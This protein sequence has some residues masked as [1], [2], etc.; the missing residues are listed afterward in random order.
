MSTPPR[1]ARRRIRDPLGYRITMATI[2]T[3]FTIVLLPVA[4]I[5]FGPVAYRLG[6]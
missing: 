1:H 5:L 6:A 2:N 4:V 3:L